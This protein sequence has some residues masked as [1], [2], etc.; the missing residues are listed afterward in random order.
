MRALVVG[1]G[2]GGLGVFRLRGMLPQPG[3]VSVSTTI[4]KLWEAIGFRHG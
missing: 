3:L 4:N 1:F 2:P